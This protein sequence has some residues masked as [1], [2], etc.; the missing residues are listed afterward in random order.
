MSTPSHI[1]IEGR[2]L[3]ANWHGPPPDQAMTL[4]FL[5][6]GLGC[7][8]LWRDFPARL[9]EA[10]GCGAL[11][12]SRLGYGRSDPCPLPRPL[13]FM[14]EEGLT[15]LPRVLAATGVNACVL[16]GH[17]DGGSIAIIYA[18]GTPAA[19]LKGLITEAA[20]VFCEPLTIGAIRE[21]KER[22]VNGDLRQRLAKY[23]GDNTGC[24]FWGWNRAWLDPG[25]AQWNI[26]GYLPAIRVP[27]LA[28]QGQNDPY[29]SATQVRAI[30]NQA[31]GPA[32]SL[33]L[34]D[35]GHSPHIDCRQATFQAMKAFI[36]ALN[37]HPPAGH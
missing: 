29:G 22:F 37:P 33:I 10:T 35:C 26:E 6:E 20:H 4:V 32:Q 18:G 34:A 1:T 8:Q 5:H 30:V 36:L 31:G 27:L 7:A 25:F 2:R 17:S 15:V 16:I 19:P 11:V 13:R 3:E 24:A 28:I 14:H 9:A 21:A 12:V 23:H